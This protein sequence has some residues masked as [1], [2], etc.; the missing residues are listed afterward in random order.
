MSG[1][2]DHA[3]AHIRNRLIN[4]EF[5]AG[6]RLNESE[7][8]ESS[9]VSRTPVRDALRRLAIEYFVRIEPN[10]GAFVI[11]WSREDIM[12]MF[13]L[14]A[15]MEGVAARKAALRAS[16]SQISDL[17][18]IIN[19]IDQVTQLENT[20][21]RDKFL[22]LNRE[23]HDA[24][25]VASGSR[26]LTEIISRLVEQA[27]VVRTASQYS[28]DDI[29]ISNQHH[30]E[31]TNAIRDQNPLLAE[32]IMRTHI[33]AASSRYSTHYMIGDAHSSKNLS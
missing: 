4:G 3:Y 12:D 30:L 28:S 13:E 14:R 16:K 25:F 17:Y 19:K 11:D 5:K 9:G 23:F 24:I 21:M 10:R 26:K 33:L 15:M 6:D 20:D 7:L 29:Q 27:V 8:S 32:S 2:T 1:A 31:L 18:N 22:T